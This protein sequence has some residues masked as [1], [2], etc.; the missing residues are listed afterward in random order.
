[1]PFKAP[2][3]KQEPGGFEGAPP[4]TLMLG[5]NGIEE[6]ATLSVGPST[7]LQSSQKLEIKATP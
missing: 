3:G 2:E 7:V 4:S 6:A 5:I 1:V